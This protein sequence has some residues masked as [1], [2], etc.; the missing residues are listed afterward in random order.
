MIFQSIGLL[1]G[2]TTRL[3]KII[4][5]CQKFDKIFL[6]VFYKILEHYAFLNLGSCSDGHGTIFC[7]PVRIWTA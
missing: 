4:N 1:D 5:P 6:Y 3:S 2:A 7:I